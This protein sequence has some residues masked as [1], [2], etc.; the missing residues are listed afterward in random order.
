MP[1]HITMDGKVEEVKPKDGKQFT[2]KELQGF[3]GGTID[4]LMFPSENVMYVN[5]NGKLEGL[6]K[7][8]K[9]TE[10]FKK[11]FPIETYP[12]NNDELIVGD[13]LVMTKEEDTIQ[14]KE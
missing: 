1:K 13:V 12:N 2:L 6:E 9:A 5:D 8:E 10:I 11:E 3:V 14:N 4:V 7:N